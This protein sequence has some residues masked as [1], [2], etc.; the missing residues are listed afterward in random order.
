MRL[1]RS[2]VVAGRRAGRPSAGPI[3]D[4]AEQRQSEDGESEPA[5]L[6]P[7]RFSYHARDHRG[8]E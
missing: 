1:G 4:E 3:T 2:R 5:R 8:P 7:C 6:S